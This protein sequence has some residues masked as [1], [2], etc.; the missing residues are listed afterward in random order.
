MAVRISIDETFPKFAGLPRA[1]IS[2]A[3]NATAPI[4]FYGFEVP[5]LTPHNVGDAGMSQRVLM[6]SIR[7]PLIF[8]NHAFASAIGSIP[9]DIYQSSRVGI[10]LADYVR[11]GVLK[12][13][14]DGVP[15]TPTEILTYTP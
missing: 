2:V 1:K 11:R 13:E 14:E 15:L 5:P 3:I 10:V 6:V 12:V 9:A 4:P 8:S 7:R